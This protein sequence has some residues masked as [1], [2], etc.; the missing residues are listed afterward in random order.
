MNR[1]HTKR[2][3][4]LLGSTG[5][6]GENTLDVIRRMSDFFE[7]AALSCRRSIDKLYKQVLE[8]S[9]Q[10][11]AITDETFNRNSCPQMFHSLRYY[12]G[13]TGL[14]QMIEEVEADIVVNAISGAKGLLPSLRTLEAEKNLALANKATIVMAGPLIM[15]TVKKNGVNLIPVDSEHYALFQM[16]KKFNTGEVS[17]IILTASGGAFR[18]LSYEELKKVRVQDALK[19]PNWNMGPKITIDSAT[20]A[21]KGL[22]FIEAH[23][24][25]NL[26]AS[27][28]EVVIHPQSAIHSLI[29]TI[30]GFLYA[31]ISK[32]D[33][34]MVIQNVLT[35]PELQP[36]NFSALD[37]AGKAFSFYPVDLKKYRLLSLARQAVER[38]GAYPIVYNAAN[39]VAVENFLQEKIALI[40]IPA[41]V[42]E[43]LGTGWDCPTGSV[44]EILAVDQMAR[45]RAGSILMNKGR[46]NLWF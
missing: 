31:Q 11:V 46:T 39:E 17:E 6:I 38:A 34:R 26:D 12:E 42:E 37:L 27:R 41:L 23:Y 1:I 44:E 9:P 4:I 32:P 2:R 15:E 29:R 36:A 16:L 10:A 8:F 19:H 33:M 45:E 21:N 43:T 30:D 7:V 13:E 18:D 24:L 5:S 35:F 3:V 40:K 20:L 22:E 25:Y 14:L 28:I